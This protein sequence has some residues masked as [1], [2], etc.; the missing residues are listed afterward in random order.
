MEI[1]F[2]SCCLIPD[3]LEPLLENTIFRIV[4]ESLTNACK[5]SKSDRIRVEVVQQDE[6]IRIE[7]RDWGTG[8]DPDNIAASCFGLRGVQERARLL[9]GRATIESKAGEGTRIAVKLPVVEK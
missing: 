8:F 6:F 2:S 1:D 9:G 4:Q 5:H 3:R 7:V